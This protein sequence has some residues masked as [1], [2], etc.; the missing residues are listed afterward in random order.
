M[1]SVA[2]CVVGASSPSCP[3]RP[4]CGKV[5]GAA[6]RRSSLRWRF[7]RFLQASKIGKFCNALPA[8]LWK[9]CRP[10][11]TPETPHCIVKPYWSLLHCTGENVVMISLVDRMRSRGRD[12]DRLE[13]L[14][15]GPA[16]VSNNPCQ[17]S[18]SVC[19][20]CRT[21]FDIEP[22]AGLLAIAGMGHRQRK[23]HTSRYA[24]CPWARP[25]DASRSPLPGGGA[26]LRPFFVGAGA[27]TDAAYWLTGGGAWGWSSC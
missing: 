11:Y 22:S 1:P 18:A 14:T 19:L 10:F 7:R 15:S 6:L 13:T 9:V 21:F 24:C 5:P 16:W 3:W 2:R 4:L 27:G 17:H 12:F 20:R 23:P 25:Y 8:L 26:G